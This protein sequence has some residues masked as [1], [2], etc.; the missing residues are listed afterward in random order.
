ML[1]NVFI[2]IFL[3]IINFIQPL[4]RIIK[5]FT[6]RNYAIDLL[7][8]SIGNIRPNFYTRFGLIANVITK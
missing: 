2:F 5:D 1:I 8:F 3:K 4:S 6:F 7:N